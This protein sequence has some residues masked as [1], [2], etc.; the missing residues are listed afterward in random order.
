MYKYNILEEWQIL[1]ISI[2]NYER[3]SKELFAYSKF[4]CAVVTK[5]DDWIAFLKLY[6]TSDNIRMKSNTTQD[7]TKFEAGKGNTVAHCGKSVGED[8]RVTVCSYCLKFHI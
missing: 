6:G 5:L 4:Q 2:K 3:C 8:A 7:C 1:D